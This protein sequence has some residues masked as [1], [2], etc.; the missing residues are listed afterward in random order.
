[1]WHKMYSLI[2]TCVQ[3][4]AKKN[5]KNPAHTAVTRQVHLERDEPHSCTVTGAR[6]SREM[7]REILAAIATRRELASRERVKLEWVIHY[8]LALGRGGWLVV[9]IHNTEYYLYYTRW[10]CPVWSMESLVMKV[11]TP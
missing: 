7:G 8:I 9:V 2:L 4:T 10:S 6:K 1:M 11:C 5:P 3:Q